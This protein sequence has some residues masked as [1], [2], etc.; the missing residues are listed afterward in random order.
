VLATRVQQPN[1]S[2][3]RRHNLAL[4]ETTVSGGSVTLSRVLA[5]G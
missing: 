3:Q 4:F 1:Q 2:V 5:H